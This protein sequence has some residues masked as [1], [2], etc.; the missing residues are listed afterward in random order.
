MPPHI[1]IESRSN[2]AGANDDRPERFNRRNDMASDRQALAALDDIDRILH[3]R[4]ARSSVG[5]GRSLNQA[6]LSAEYW[7]VRTR[8]DTALILIDKIPV[9]GKRIATAV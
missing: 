4:I 5:D 2:G 8:L 6:E 3:E 1:A 9:Y 7:Q